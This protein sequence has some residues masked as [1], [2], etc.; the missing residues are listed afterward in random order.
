MKDSSAQPARQPF[1]P[2]IYYR[3]CLFLLLFIAT[4]ASFNGYYAKWRFL[5]GAPGNGFSGMVDG[6]AN[7]P[8]VYRQL[9][10]A[11]AN[12]VDHKT[13]D[14]LKDRAFSARNRTGELVR[15][16]L[17][18]APLALSRT[19]FL[20]YWVVYGSVL[21]FAWLATWSMYRL[22]RHLG[23]ETRTAAAAATIVMLLMPYLLSG[24]GYLYDYPELAFFVIAVWMALKLDW[25][26]MIPVAALATWNKE[27]FLLFIP[28]LYPLLR[29]RGSAI[30]SIIGTAA[31]AATCLAVYLPIR[32]RFQHNP[33]GT[34]QF[35]LWDQIHFVLHPATWFLPEKTYGIVLFQSLNPLTVAL[36]AWTACRGWRSLSKPIQRHAQIAAAINIPLFIL[37]C[38]PGELRDL[39]FLYVPFLLLLAA[40]LAGWPADR[41]LA[42]IKSDEEL[43]RRQAT[44]ST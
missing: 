42:T 15:E 1:A 36:I 21:L 14:Q 20:R 7:R 26:W 40:N 9:L 3:L 32:A 31:L 25:W 12:W 33:G 44:V 18:S 5:D 6:T 30:K 17:F 16:R 34:V 28:T 38:D 35:H 19:Y 43:E 11:I 4:A 27:S 8:F 22:C 29:Q 13:P 39:S 10:P 41:R 24:G 37:C 23:Y 2:N